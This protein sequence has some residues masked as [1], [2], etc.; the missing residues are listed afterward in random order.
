[1]RLVELNG[2]EIGYLVS[3]ASESTSSKHSD[4]SLRP[5]VNRRVEPLLLAKVQYVGLSRKQFQQV[6][7]RQKRWPAVLAES[8]KVIASFMIALR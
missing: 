4:E 8:G 5:G 7:S 3:R 1:M 2:K 6:T